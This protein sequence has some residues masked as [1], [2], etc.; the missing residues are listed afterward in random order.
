[1]QASVLKAG[2][3]AG[4]I[5]GAVDLVLLMGMLLAQGVPAGVPVRMTAAVMLGTGVLPPPNTIEPGIVGAALVVHFGLSLVCGVIIALLIQRLDRM[6]ALAVGVGFGLA[7]WIVN[8]FAIAPVMFP[9]LTAMRSAPT[10]PFA[11]AVFG[12]AAVGAYLALTAADRR[13]GADR[14]KVDQPVTPERRRP[15]ERRGP[16]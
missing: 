2:L 4:L 7:M 11:H 8:Y 1:M 6:P 14:R 5:A 10:T 9:W 15:F 16:A 3:W 12:V 13:A